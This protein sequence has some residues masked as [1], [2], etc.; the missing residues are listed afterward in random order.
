VVEVDE[1]RKRISLTLR[2]DDEA[3][4]AKPERGPRRDRPERGNRKGGNQSPD[5]SADRGA[6]RRGTRERRD[7]GRSERSAAPS[8]SAMADALRRA[9]LTGK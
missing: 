8:N 1:A 4:A 2:L 3:N 7:A 6:D 5:R 9:G